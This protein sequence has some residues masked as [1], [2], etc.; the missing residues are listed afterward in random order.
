[1]AKLNFGKEAAISE[2]D[3]KVYINFEANV[4]QVS[5]SLGKNGMY[6]INVNGNVQSVSQADFKKIVFIPKENAGNFNYSFGKGVSL[7]DVGIN[8]T[9]NGPLTTLQFYGPQNKFTRVITSK[10]DDNVRVSQNS[11]GSY[12]INSNGAKLTL[13]YIASDNEQVSIYT[14]DGNDTINIDDSVTGTVLVN[15]GSG[16]NIVNGSRDGRIIVEG[17]GNNKITLGGTKPDAKG[18]YGI[19]DNI[20][21]LGDGNNTIVARGT[22]QNYIGVGNGANDIKMNDGN[23]TV[24][25]GNGKAGDGNNMNRI[26][27]GKGENV[28]YAGAG[29]NIIDNS[30]GKNTINVGSSN[31]TLSNTSKDTLI[32]ITQ[33]DFYSTYNINPKGI[34]VQ[35]DAAFKEKT[36]EYLKTIASTPAGKKMLQEMSNSGQTTT[37]IPANFSNSTNNATGRADGLDSENFKQGEKLP[38]SNATIQYNPNMTTD[39]PTSGK[40]LADSPV[41]VLAHELGHGWAI[42]TGNQVGGYYNSFTGEKQGAN[43]S[44][45]G[46]VPNEEVANTSGR[47]T[48]VSNVNGDVPEVVNYNITGARVTEDLIRKQVG[49]VRQTVSPRTNYRADPVPVKQSGVNNP[50]NSQAAPAAKVQQDPKNSQKENKNQGP[51]MRM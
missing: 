7:S 26:I 9:D 17:D 25:I 50:T 27:T 28:L 43:D 19:S 37:I 45:H 35:G 49:G 31:T 6:D 4:R 21:N 20:V 24:R 44:A 5:V 1:M 22:G 15:S 16:N 36:F 42:N 10:N 18:N 23:G 14:R 51:K 11:D 29:K 40:G 47:Y 46:R 13:P 48:G 3:G 8:A 33:N 32:P 30:L 34:I 39:L 41:F 2:A 38:K 12:E